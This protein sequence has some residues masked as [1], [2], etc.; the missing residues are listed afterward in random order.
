MPL[1]LNKLRLSLSIV[2]LL[3]MAF[4]WTGQ[5]DRHNLC[6]LCFCDVT[7]IDPIQPGGG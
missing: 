5:I 4:S 6:L 7:S 3:L 2:G 1:K